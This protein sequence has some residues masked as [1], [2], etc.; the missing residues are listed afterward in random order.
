MKI[1][2]K[3]KKIPTIFKIYKATCDIC[4]CEFEFDQNEIKSGH[5]I[6]FSNY[7]FC[8]NPSC[9]HVITENEFEFVRNR[10]VY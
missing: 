9:T 8:P 2:K 6:F 5:D 10:E 7:I 1:L 4:G 3:G